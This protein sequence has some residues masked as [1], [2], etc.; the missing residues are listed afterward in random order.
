[1]TLLGGGVAWVINLGILLQRQ[2]PNARKEA[3]NAVMVSDPRRAS[4]MAAARQIYQ[5][6]IW[7]LKMGLSLTTLNM[8][9][10]AELLP[11]LGGWLKG[12][13]GGS[14]SPPPLNSNGL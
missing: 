3:E 9:F 10:I 1:M 4:E 13:G 6:K 8:G 12:L 11:E 14:P 5:H 2:L 7:S